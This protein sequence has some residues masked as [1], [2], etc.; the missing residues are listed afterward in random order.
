[1]LLRISDARIIFRQLAMFVFEVNLEMRE[2][3][4]ILPFMGGRQRPNAP[5]SPSLDSPSS[6]TG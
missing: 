5:F 3:M 4:I 1:V 6:I 2:A